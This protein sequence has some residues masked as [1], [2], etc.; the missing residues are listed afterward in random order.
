MIIWTRINVR[1]SFDRHQIRYTQ[2]RFEWKEDIDLLTQ[3]PQTTV[4]TEYECEDHVLGHTDTFI[5]FKSLNIKCQDEPTVEY[6]SDI[7]TPKSAKTQTQ[8][9][10]PKMTACSSVRLVTYKIA[11]KSCLHPFSKRSWVLNGTVLKCGHRVQD[12]S[13]DWVD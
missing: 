2:M 5:S 10:T 12:R 3:N 1:L 9:R 13:V 6:K 7:P 8:I 4:L 11:L